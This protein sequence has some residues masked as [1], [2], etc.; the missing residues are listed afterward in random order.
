MARGTR[1]LERTGV[2]AVLIART[3]RQRNTSGPDRRKQ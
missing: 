3:G 1:L 2:E